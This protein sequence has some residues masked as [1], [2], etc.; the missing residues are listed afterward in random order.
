MELS[1]LNMNE[2][3]L[4]NYCSSLST[5]QLYELANRQSRI[6][7]ICRRVY[8]QKTNGY[9]CKNCGHYNNGHNGSNGMLESAL[10][11]GGGAAVGTA[12][13]G[14]LGGAIGGGL[15]G[16]LSSKGTTEQRLTKGLIGG[17]GGGLGAG[18]GGVPGSAV[19]GGLAG[20]LSSRI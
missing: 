13:A 14:P 5:D 20:A 11:T 19:G 15:G 7:D 1:T 4:V 8:Q 18:L 6:Y 16:Y 17:L 10:V 3:D 2:S 12:L 9:H